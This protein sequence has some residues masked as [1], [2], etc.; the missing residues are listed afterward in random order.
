MSRP[1]STV[2]ANIYDW[3][4]SEE[5]ARACRDISE[6][7][8]REQPGNFV[9]HIC[10]STASKIADELASARLVLAWLLTAL[11]APAFLLATLVPIR[12]AGALLPQLAVAG[13]VRAVSVRKWFWVAGSIVQAVCVIAMA[14]VAWIG[15]G[16][17][18]GWAIVAL[19]ALFSIA[20]GVCSVAHK[21]VLGKTIARSRRGTVMGYAGAIAGVATVAIG[22]WVAATTGAPGTHGVMAF[23]LLGAGGLWLTAA[24]LFA[25]IAE[26]PGATEG[27]AN[28]LSLGLTS[29]VLL[30]RDRRLLHFIVTRGLLL[31][32]ALSV[33][34]YVSLA[35]RKLGTED[36]ALGVLLLASGLAAAI[37]APVW[38]RFADRSSRRVLAVAATITGILG[39]VTFV[40]TSGV[41]GIASSRWFYGGLLFVIALAHQGVRLGRKTYLIDLAGA[42]N[43]AG[44]VA[45]SN[46]V[47]G[48]LLLLASAVGTLAEAFGDRWVILILA[49]LALGAA[50]SAVALNEVEG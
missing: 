8:C 25:G 2:A 43:R 44:Y 17:G 29:L 33:P 41:S 21:D 36:A 13:M 5:D 38:G 45:V 34:F 1:G 6:Q 37:S 30:R 22:S 11:G 10:A 42:D 24:A 35:G 49:L 16:S 7:A 47:I 27:G 12:E 46:S 20:R 19:L 31:S 28:A 15:H 40:L 23:M 32:T 14:A 39:V 18:A 9:I 26:S 48:I 3:L 4:T 50:G